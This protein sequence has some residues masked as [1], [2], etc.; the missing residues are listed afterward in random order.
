MS[1][2][3]D[4]P[5]P[6]SGRF[7]ALEVFCFYRFLFKAPIENLPI[8]LKLEKGD[9]GWGVRMIWLKPSLGFH[10]LNTLNQA[11]DRRQPLMLKSPLPSYGQQG[12]VGPKHGLLNAVREAGDR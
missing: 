8:S 2:E 6:T 12:R 11:K 1:G 10:G 3:Q 9:W 7:D 5:E 4:A